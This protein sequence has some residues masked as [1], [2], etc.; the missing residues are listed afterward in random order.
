MDGID[1]SVLLPRSSSSCSDLVDLDDSIVKLPT[2]Y[3]AV[4]FSIPPTDSNCLYFDGL[5]VAGSSVEIPSYN[6]LPISL[7]RDRE[8]EVVSCLPRPAVAPLHQQSASLLQHCTTKRHIAASEFKP[9]EQRQRRTV[10]RR[11][12]S[13]KCHPPTE[14]SMSSRDQRMRRIE[15]R[16]ARKKQE[17]DM[18]KDEEDQEGADEEDEPVKQ[19]RKPRQKRATCV[20]TIPDVHFPKCKFRLPKKGSIERSCKEGFVYVQELF[21]ERRRLQWP[22]TTES[23]RE[24]IAKVFECDME[25]ATLVL[26]GTRV[27]DVTPVN[28]LYRGCILY[29]VRPPNNSKRGG[30][31]QFGDRKFVFIRPAGCDMP[32][33]SIAYIYDFFKND[34]NTESI[35][36]RNS[37]ILNDVPIFICSQFSKMSCKLFDVI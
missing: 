31:K 23:L 22:E 17:E 11:R 24:E 13:I 4:S 33:I 36:N 21:G 3:G 7:H 30:A 6:G 5:S 26:D 35:Q 9:V 37:S 15:E 27:Y 25:K 16:E 1:K 10:P 2:V 12:G 8:V 14:K 28:C 29:L 32:V 34:V 20:P 19:Q 18:E